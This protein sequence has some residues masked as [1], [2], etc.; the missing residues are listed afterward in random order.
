MRYY[1]KGNG[2]S[3]LEGCIWKA[4]TQQ[5]L[6]LPCSCT[7]RASH[8]LVLPSIHAYIYFSLFLRPCAIKAELHST[9]GRGMAVCSDENSMPSPPFYEEM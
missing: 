9:S 5:G 6:G 3:L 1:L 8:P 7:D 4:F 2:T